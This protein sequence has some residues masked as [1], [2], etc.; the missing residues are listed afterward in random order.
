VIYR[1]ESKR[2]SSQVLDE[3]QHR[4]QQQQ[5][6]KDRAEYLI[7]DLKEYKFIHDHKNQQG[8]Y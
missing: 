5:E 1:T 7:L 2:D 8:Q 4:H 3:E 6:T